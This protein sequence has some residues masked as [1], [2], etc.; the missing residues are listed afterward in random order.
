MSS[1]HKDW[2]ASRGPRILY[3]HGK[4]HRATREAAEQVYLSWQAMQ[5]DKKLYGSRG[6]SFYFSSQDPA[7]DSTVGFLSSLILQSSP[8]LAA[9]YLDPKL[10]FVQ[11]QFQL[12]HR[13]NEK[14]LLNLF[15][16]LNMCAR[17]TEDL[18]LLQDI[19]Q[20]KG[21]EEFWTL[22]NDLAA[23][24]ESSLALVVT[25]GP[26]RH[27]HD[28]IKAW[29]DIPI[30]Q[31][32]LTGNIENLKVASGE[33]GYLDT[34]ISGL[35]PGG[36]GEARIRNSLQKLMDMSEDTLTKSLELIKDHTNWPKTASVKALSKFCSLIET[37]TPSS[38]PSMVL[39][40]ILRSNHDQDRFQWILKWLLCGY[41]PLT[42]K[43]LAMLL[44]YYQ[45]TDEWTFVTPSS[46]DLQ[47]AIH[48]LDIW[49]CGIVHFSHD[50]VCIR[51]S[52]WDVLEPGMAH[53]WDE[54]RSSA[55]STIITFILAY[56][57]MPEVQEN[58]S[59]K[60]S[61]YESLVQASGNEITPPL[62]PDGQDFVFYAVQAF[63]R[64][65][66]ENLL[67][68]ES[69][70]KD[71]ISCQGPMT[72]WMKAYWAISNPFSRPRLETLTSASEI[73][74]ASA[75]LSPRAVKILRKFKTD[76]KN[77]SGP[78]RKLSE[79]DALVEAT[80]AGNQDLALEC[81]GQIVSASKRQQTDENDQDL[82]GGMLDILWPSLVLWMATWL[83][84]DRLVDLLLIN[85]IK[86]DPDDN[87]SRFF[88]SPLYMA[89]RMGHTVITRALL[90]YGA[91][92]DV[93][94][95]ETYSS[96]Y[97]AAASGHIDI[98]KALVKKDNSLLE[99]QTPN[100]P[101]YVASIRGNWK[102]VE[103]LCALKADPDSG[104]EPRSGDRWAPLIAAAEYG[105]VKTLKVLLV[106]KADVNI[107]GPSGD[108]PLWFAAVRAASLECVRLLLD[109]NAD[110]NHE[111]IDPPLLV[112][113]M[114]SG[115]LVEERLAMFD[116]LIR[117]DPPIQ[118]DR[119]DPYTEMT[120]LMHA[121]QAGETAVVKWLLEHG[122]DVNITNDSG[123]G[124]VYHGIVNHH[125]EVLRELL[126]WEP[127]LDGVTDSGVTL[128]QIAADDAF[129]VEM[130]LD[131]GANAELTNGSRQTVINIAVGKEKAD[132]VRL[133]AS[134]KVDIHHRDQYGWTPIHDATGY[135]PNA[136]IVRILMEGG[137]NLKDTLNDGRNPLHLAAPRYPEILRILLEF[138]GALDLEKRNDYGETPLL[139]L[140]LYSEIESFKLLVRAGANI[141]TQGLRGWTPLMKAVNDDMPD[142]AMDFLLSQPDIKVNIQGK[143]ETALHIA[144]QRLSLSYLVKLVSHGADPNCHV[145]DFKSTP[146]IASCFPSGGA[147]SQQFEQMERVVRELVD[148]PKHP[149]DVKAMHGTTVYNA[150]CAAALAGGP[151]VVDCLLTAGASTED[152]DPLGRVPLHFAAANDIRNFE[153]VK[154]AYKEDLMISDRFGKN[155]LHWAAQFGQVKTVKDILNSFATKQERNKHINKPDV[156]GWTA[157]CWACRPFTGGFTASEER[158]FAG[159]I[160]YLLDNGAD[161]VVEF[162]MGQ[163]DTVETFTPFKLA[164][165]CNANDKIIDLL[166]RGPEGNLG[167]DAKKVDIDSETPCQKYTAWGTICDVCLT[168]SRPILSLFFSIIFS[169]LPSS[170]TQIVSGAAAATDPKSMFGSSF[171]C[172]S[173]N[174]FDACKKCYGRIDEYHSHLRKE[175]GQPHEFRFR[176]G[177]EQEFQDPSIPS[178]PRWVS[179][180]ELVSSNGSRGRQ[181]PE[182]TPLE[183]GDTLDDSD[184]LEFSDLSDPYEDHSPP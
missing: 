160:S 110:P 77:G 49:L 7:R 72:L 39:N 173:C 113:M 101:L 154:L 30:H 105:F 95:D 147:R 38:T 118:L 78:I 89:A 4:D 167:S 54:V 36:H 80:R 84:M 83:N 121:A 106:N 107:S 76:G 152:Q 70:E 52:I 74:L 98:V 21:W 57:F 157:L 132:V 123:V 26:S 96:I 44:C 145:L 59:F 162:R 56:L 124:A 92:I 2:R 67:V 178:P 97:T 99:I 19:D 150:I 177:R 159:T 120:P 90:K 25:S 29:P 34:L 109:K 172:Q 61:Q 114:E 126:K 119:A 28:R 133:L 104:I 138:H 134:R 15:M 32:T 33:E 48:Q 141:N 148:H 27:L 175:D 3:I 81:A 129:L 146:L 40:Q 55:P 73:L 24:T 100:S 31:Y 153:R 45:R 8:G 79:M 131:A 135:V 163:G 17:I 9:R 183:E 14:D 136:E 46:T 176:E 142:G 94:R 18:L 108:T 85:G 23:T 87:T 171:Q 50:Q 60:C 170:S 20:C 68:L 11:D 111:L 116:L 47:D 35:C 1:E 137:A 144:C 12:H 130:L 13:W 122:A 22:L 184:E 151:G 112:Q 166:A 169:T 51:E 66:S 143:G 164:K 181:T 5:R 115:V 62:R 174:D 58:L 127:Q 10:D 102:A 165:L 168:V 156:D 71:L 125:V 158:D 63:P 103:A 180:N 93:V 43:E 75:N 155:V 42:R 182:A 179:T 53:V 69:L 82:R 149:A 37:V 86:P 139:I 161:R 128:L 16:M 88:P 65:L 6:F 140:K 117:N 91:R 64:H 41:R